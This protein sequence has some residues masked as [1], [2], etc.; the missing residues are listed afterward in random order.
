[1]TQ[2]AHP[3]CSSA[4]LSSPTAC[5]A[6]CTPPVKPEVLQNVYRSPDFRHA[7]SSFAPAALIDFYFSPKVSS[8]KLCIKPFCNKPCNFYL[9]SHPSKKL[10]FQKTAVPTKNTASLGE[11]LVLLP[12]LLQYL[13]ISTH[14]RDPTL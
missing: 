2:G 9:I 10:A 7:Q 6:A 1:M 8:G 5:S 11:A 12:M 4:S 14:K 13:G 3:G